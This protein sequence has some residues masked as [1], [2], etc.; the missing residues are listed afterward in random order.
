M[1]QTIDANGAIHD[2]AG[3]F[4]GHIKT[5]GD[6][7]S[8]LA[9]DLPDILTDPRVI[10]ALGE[11]P[12]LDEFDQGMLRILLDP[13]NDR[14]GNAF[15]L[16]D[17]L[18]QL[19]GFEASTEDL[20]Q[21]ADRLGGFY[22]KTEGGYE[23]FLFDAF[24]DDEYGWGIVSAYLPGHDTQR[25]SQGFDL[26]HLRPEAGASGLRTAV[27][28]AGWMASYRDE[29]QK[30]LAALAAPKPARPTIAR[31]QT[32]VAV[33]D[34]IHNGR[35]ASFSRDGGTTIIEGTIRHGAWTAEGQVAG[36]DID[37]RDACMRVT[38]HTGMEMFLPFAEM[39]D[40]HEA[41]YLA[42]R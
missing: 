41:G 25:I 8:A 9:N 34:A 31:M 18:D 14:G 35:K 22:D 27:N 21:V 26:K 7:T 10:E 42:I 13:D 5:E 15:E 32:E 19:D 40:I 17:I 24:D 11:G 3:R 20:W 12:D 29:I 33:M 23:S 36:H 16:E 28:A 39:A 6:A 2:S 1:T 38:T 4:D 37:P 30:T